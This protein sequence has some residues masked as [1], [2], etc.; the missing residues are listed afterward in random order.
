MVPVS[1]ATN[2]QRGSKSLRRALLGTISSPLYGYWRASRP[3]GRNLSGRSPRFPLRSGASDNGVVAEF[4]RLH[5][6]WKMGR[7][8]DRETEIVGD[9]DT[10]SVNLSINA[11]NTTQFGSDARYMIR[12]A[13]SAGITVKSCAPSTHLNN[14]PRSDHEG[15]ATNW[16]GRLY[17]FNDDYFEALKQLVESAAGFLCSRAR[18][19]LDRCGI[20]SQRRRIHALSF[21]G[22]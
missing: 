9:R 17:V 7:W 21:V 12:R 15:D 13:E 20:V 16:S 22:N 18:R 2:R 11:N 4:V 19:C 5:P 14:S 3:R 10:V 8:L 1:A 6:F